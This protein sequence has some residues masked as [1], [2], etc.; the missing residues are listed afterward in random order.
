MSKRLLPILLLLC[1]WLAAQTTLTNEIRITPKTSTPAY[2]DSKYHIIVNSTLGQKVGVSPLG[3]NFELPQLVGI[4]HVVNNQ[5]ASIPATT[6]YAVPA[7][8]DGVYQLCQN[9][10]IDTVG[11]VSSGGTIQGQFTWTDKNSNTHQFSVNAAIAGS[12]INDTEGGCF[13][14]QAKGGTNIQYAILAAGTYTV[15]PIYD[16]NVV[17]IRLE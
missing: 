14:V 9:L 6:L 17:A 16:Y 3:V 1:S 8:A 13:N 15:I 2:N 11:V 10:F 5:T 12:S 7:G 4:A